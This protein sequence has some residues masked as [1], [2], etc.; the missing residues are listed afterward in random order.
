MN[1]LRRMITKCGIDYFLFS[2]ISFPLKYV[3]G[4]DWRTSVKGKIL[5][6][7]I[8]GKIKEQYGLTFLNKTAPFY[9][10]C[11]VE[12]F[13]DKIYDTFPITAKDI[14][15]DIGATAG[16]YSL[17]CAKQGA[18]VYAFEPDKSA[19]ELMLTHIDINNMTNRIYAISQFVNSKN[20][21]DK[22]SKTHEKPTLLKIDVEGSEV[23]VL[24]GAKLTI[25]KKP[26]IILETHSKTLKNECIE[27]L[28]KHNY[29]IVKEIK[30]DNN[31]D[32]LF[33][34]QIKV[35]H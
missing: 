5:W 13:L 17:L 8:S 26:R 22:F 23:D 10:F 30:I 25:K 15:Y 27:L 32:L 14:V 11:L 12:I 31:T 1:S 9:P 2:I 16:E 34:D 4:S 20:S 3:G 24:N 21:I 7:K 29:T 6:N 19:Y 33:L 35:T 28:K 18:K